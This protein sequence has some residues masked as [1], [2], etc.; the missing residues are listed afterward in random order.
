MTD[1]TKTNKWVEENEFDVKDDKF[2]NL[3]IHLTKDLEFKKGD[4]LF[5]YKPFEK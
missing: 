5:I 4:N 1:K 2:G 3:I